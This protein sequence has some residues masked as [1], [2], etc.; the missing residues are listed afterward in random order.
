MRHSEDVRQAVSKLL[1]DGEFRASKRNRRFLDFV[2]EETLEGR[3]DRI[4]AYTIAVDVFGRSTDF[5]PSTDPIVRIEAARLRTALRDYYDGP[6][7]TADLRIVLP[8]GR[9]LPEFV[10]SSDQCVAGIFADELGDRTK[11]LIEVDASSERM[12]DVLDAA[13]ELTIDTLRLR[14]L[15]VFFVSPNTKLSNIEFVDRLLEGSSTAL[16]V[17][18]SERAGAIRWRVSA[19]PTCEIMFS[20]K[21][22]V[23]GNADHLSI[24]LSAA[25]QQIAR[26]I[27][28]LRAV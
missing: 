11:V 21:I 15:R 27:L 4:K 5:D 20:S 19:L 16:V 1:A 18:L 7:A 17:S 14:D 28:N 6:G 9:Y 25:A 12:S 23:Q 2:V 3:G 10:R 24:D 26:L 8:L 13:L 22:K